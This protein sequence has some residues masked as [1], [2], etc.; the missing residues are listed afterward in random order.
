MRIRLAFAFAVLILFLASP[1]GMAQFTTGAL[2]GVVVDPTGASVPQAKVTVL[3]KDTGYSRTDGRA[4]DGTFSFPALPVGAYRLTVE[5]E[6]FRTHVQEGITLAVNRAASQRV[7]L[8]VGATTQ[9]ITVVENAAM[10][11]AQSATINQL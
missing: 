10:V 8:Q 7:T 9:E 2:S 5:H 3:N 6:G 1:S 4:T 11:N